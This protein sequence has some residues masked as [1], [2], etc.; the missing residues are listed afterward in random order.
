MAK[1]T[2]PIPV[3][4]RPC[5]DIPIWPG[6][7]AIHEQ[8]GLWIFHTQPEAV[9]PPKPEITPRRFQFYGLSHLIR[10]KGWYWTPAG[11]RRTVVPG[12]MILTLPG[13]IQDYGGDRKP[14]VEDALC[15]HGPAADHLAACGVLKD[16]ILDVGT[17]RR[18]L[19]IIETAAHPSPDEQIR[20]NMMLQQL[21]VDLYLERQQGSDRTRQSPLDSLL[22]Q[23]L[24]TPKKWWSVKEMAAYCGLSQNQFRRVF[25]AHTGSAPKRYVDHFKATLA[26]GK[27]C[28]SADSIAVIAA[29]LGYA[30]PYHFSRRFKAITGLAPERYRKIYSINVELMCRTKSEKSVSRVVTIEK[31]IAQSMS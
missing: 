16:G 30:D 25:E 23:L 5:E 15:F 6:E 28:G 7:Q 29:S 1:R 3:E 10:G 19:P 18:L 27:L 12:Q 26:G 11:G 4:A 21:L 2:H 17:G 31:T 22:D 14:Y 9:W 20:A 24:K 8:Y 13:T